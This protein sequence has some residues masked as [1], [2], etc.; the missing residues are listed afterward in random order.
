MSVSHRK[1]MLVSSVAALVA[2]VGA[3]VAA[4]APTDSTPIG[5]LP[6]GPVT[7]IATSPGE[8]VAVA[9]PRQK[10]SSGLVWRVARSVDS[11]VLRQVSEADVGGAVVVVFKAIR[12]GNAT[13]VFA[14]T[15]GESSSK[16]LNARTYRVRAA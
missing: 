10:A 16:A 9:L 6:K 2:A 1:S 14:L 11:R 12:T 13:I 15:R 4:A 5:P 3:G 7:T 8:L